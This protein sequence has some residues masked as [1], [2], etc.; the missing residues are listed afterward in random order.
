MLGRY[1]TKKEIKRLK[2]EIIKEYDKKLELR[3]LR[4]ENKKLRGE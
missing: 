2:A 3:R 1:Y 4:I